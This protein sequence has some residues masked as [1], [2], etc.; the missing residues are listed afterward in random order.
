MPS[1]ISYEIICALDRKPPNRAYLLFEAQPARTIP[2]TPSEEIASM[3]RNPTGRSAR[4]MSMRPHGVGIGAPNG[5]THQVVSAGMN[6]R[7]GARM[8][9]GLY[10]ASG[11]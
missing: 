9:S 3:K 10:A 1:D 7:I 2:Y 11:Y 8:K 5:I 4:T 6:E